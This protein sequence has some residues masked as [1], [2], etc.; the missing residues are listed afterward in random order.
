VEKLGDEDV[1]RNRPVLSSFGASQFAVISD[2]TVS[3]SVCVAWYE[4]AD[5]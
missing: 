2:W 5:P 3:V 4:R 1:D